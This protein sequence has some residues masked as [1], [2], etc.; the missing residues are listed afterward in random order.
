VFPAGGQAEIGTVTSG[1]MG[2]SVGKAIGLAYV[3]AA[4]STVGSGFEVGIRNKHVKAEV[5]K[6]PFYQ[7]PGAAKP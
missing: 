2:P 1:T 3:P 5:A 6:T 7:R 4:L